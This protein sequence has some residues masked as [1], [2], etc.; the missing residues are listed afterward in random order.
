MHVNTRYVNST[1]IVSLNNYNQQ[2]FNNKIIINKILSLKKQALNWPFSWQHPTCPW[3]H[4]L[5]TAAGSPVWSSSWWC[6]AES[7]TQRSLKKNKKSLGLVISFL[8]SYQVQIDSLEIAQSPGKSLSW[9]KNNWN[10]GWF[11]PFLARVINKNAAGL[12]CSSSKVFKE[13]FFSSLSFYLH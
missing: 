12:T 8:T 2:C 6:H 4:P 7:P 10:K 3:H 13:G 11:W 9:D 1:I 5:R